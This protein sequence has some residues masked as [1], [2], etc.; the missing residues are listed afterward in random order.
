[1]LRYS[2]RALPSVSH[3]APLIERCALLIDRQAWC[4]T[5]MRGCVQPTD[6][7]AFPGQVPPHRKPRL[8]GSAPRPA[9]VLQNSVTGLQDRALGCLRRRRPTVPDLP[10]DPTVRPNMRRV[11]DI[12][13]L[14]H[15]TYVCRERRQTPRLSHA[16]SLC[17]G[18]PIMK[19]GGNKDADQDY[20]QNA[21]R[22]STF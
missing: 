11:A 16:R 21:N 14:L 20:S 1:M 15:W 3:C 9:S 13:E 18:R 12:G 17:V 10:A 6:L 5:D 22:S 2:T 7:R 4:A 19:G 8:T